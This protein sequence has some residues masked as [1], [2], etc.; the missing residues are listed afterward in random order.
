MSHAN[1]Y[2]EGGHTPVLLHEVIDG[3]AITP[4]DVVVDCT[5][6]GAG[7]SRAI[8]ARLGREGALVAIDR[9]EAALRLAR[10]ALKDAVPVCHFVCDNY[11]NLDAI[12]ESLAIPAVDKVLIDLGLSSFQLEHSGRGFSFR[13]D[14]PL[15]MTFSETGAEGIDAAQIVNTWSEEALVELLAEL[16]EERHARRIA[17]AITAARETSPFATT[18]QLAQCIEAAVPRARGKRGIHPA[19]QTFQ[20]LR[21]AVNSELTSLMEG[22]DAAARRLHPKGRIAVISF[23]SISDRIVKRTFARLASEGGWERVTRKV[24]VPG[25]EELARNPRARSAK[26]RIIEKIT[27]N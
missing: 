9:D 4:T 18:A 15:S 23:E 8:A 19:T 25:E 24:V 21:M 6:G 17:R 14:E 11:R 3:L 22:L 10:E 26:L 5:V 2:P 1:Q 12:L 16:G 7:H 13:N 20:A 27:N